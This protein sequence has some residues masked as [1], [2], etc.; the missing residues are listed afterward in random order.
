MMYSTLRTGFGGVGMGFTGQKD[1]RGFSL[2]AGV[3]GKCIWGM[4]FMQEMH[5]WLYW[6]YR[7]Q[8]ASLSSEHTSSS[9][10]SIAL[11]CS[12]IASANGDNRYPARLTIP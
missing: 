7:E 5:G 1:R 9:T 11:I 3:F 6:R 4:G 12:I 10:A 8:T 2:S